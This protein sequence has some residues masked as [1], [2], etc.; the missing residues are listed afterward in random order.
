MASDGATVLRE[1]RLLRGR[2]GEKFWI[3]CWAR[4]GCVA[5]VGGAARSAGVARG[6]VQLTVRLWRG[7]LSSSPVAAAG[8]EQGCADNGDRDRRLGTGDRGAEDALGAVG[9][10]GLEYELAGVGDIEL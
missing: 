1:T 9:E 5:R 7:A 3:F 10:R 6:G 2:S 4:N 8:A